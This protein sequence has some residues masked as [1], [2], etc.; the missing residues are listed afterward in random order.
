MVKKKEILDHVEKVLGSDILCWSASFFNKE[1]HDPNMVS[2]HQDL[3]YWGLEPLEI[4]TAWI[5]LTPS[6]KENGCMRVVPGSQAQGQI[7]QEI[8]VD[9]SEDQA[10]DL[11]LKPGKMSLHDVLIIH[12]SKS[13]LSD[14]PRY[15]FAVCYIPTSCKQIGGRTTEILVRGEDRFNHF[16]PVPWPQSDLYPDALALQHQVNEK[17]KSIYLPVPRTLDDC[18]AKET[19]DL[20]F[21]GSSGSIVA[22]GNIELNP[23]V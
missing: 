8:Q 2:W 16:V 7:G 23:S 13:N 14:I 6:T 4:V 18:P 17:M 21:V 1:A 20:S 9:V 15:G 22:D 12:G 19:I 11:E 3:T 5:A 10:V